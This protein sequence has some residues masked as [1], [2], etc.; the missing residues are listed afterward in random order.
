MATPPVD[1]NLLFKGFFQ[2]LCPISGKPSNFTAEKGEQN[3]KK[4]RRFS[5]GTVATH[6]LPFWFW[7]YS[8][9]FGK[10]YILPQDL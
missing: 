7:F 9:T 5:I 3:K 2:N 8:K 10:V 1:S 6:A 4:D